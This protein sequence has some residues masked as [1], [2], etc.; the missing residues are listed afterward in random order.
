[1][2]QLKS[3]A[4]PLSLMAVLSPALVYAQSTPVEVDSPNHQIA[5]SFKVQQGKD[6]QAAG[7]DGQ[8]VYAVTFHR[9][10]IFEDS[11]LSLELANQAPLGATVHIASTTPGSGADDYSL[12]AGKTSAVHDPYNSLILQA[13]ESG[14]AGRVFEVEAGEVDVDRD[15]ALTENVV[16]EVV[17]E[18]GPHLRGGGILGL[19]DS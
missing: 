13:R 14:G 18:V 6:K 5:L 11:A 4:F 3:L 17:D 10:K 19:A 9:K 1:M 7:T 16:V 15:V 12:L 8:L 2:P